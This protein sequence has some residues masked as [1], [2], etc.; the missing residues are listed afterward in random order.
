MIKGEFLKKEGETVVLDYSKKIEKII[1]K[2]DN[3]AD[4][5]PNK[6]LILGAA[7][8][9]RKQFNPAT[10]ETNIYVDFGSQINK[11]IFTVTGVASVSQTEYTNAY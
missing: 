6:N 3:A 10:T 11:S 7:H 2:N 5:I 4:V 9:Q 1:E 8:I